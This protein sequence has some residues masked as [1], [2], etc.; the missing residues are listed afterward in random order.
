MEALLSR[1]LEQ[2]AENVE[3]Y[4]QR[5]RNNAENQA[6][7]EDLLL[8][9][10]AALMFL[11][12]GFHVVFRESPD[13][14]IKFGQ[15]VAYAEVKHF[16]EKEQDGLDEEAM[17]EATDVLV[18][19]GDLTETEGIPPWKQ[20]ANVAIRKSKQYMSNAPNVLIIESSSESLQLMA[21]SA[22]NEYDEIVAQSDDERLKRLNA[23]MLIHT[24]SVGFRG[25]LHN[26]EFCLT[27]CPT[28]AFSPIMTAA[29]ANI[30][31]DWES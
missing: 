18:R 7:F 24:G 9:G 8:E 15:E 27:N 20:I 25:D 6:V 17:L 10:R 13:L 19:I 31:L 4:K 21:Q 14:Q 29:L 28:V 1:L 5:L 23:I 16:K 26:V 12:N 22:V 2:G 3:E 30:R 11:S